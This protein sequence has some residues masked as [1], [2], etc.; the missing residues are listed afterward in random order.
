MQ[1]GRSFWSLCFSGLALLFNFFNLRLFLNHDG[2]RCRPFAKFHGRTHPRPDTIL[3]VARFGHEDVNPPI[4]VLDR[5]CKAEAPSNQGKAP[6]LRHI[7]MTRWA[8]SRWYLLDSQSFFL[9]SFLWVSLPRCPDP[10]L[11]L[12]STPEQDTPDYVEIR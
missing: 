8:T 5:L 6:D 7:P 12:P 2:E 4:S 11:R 9:L 3:L 10:H 1:R